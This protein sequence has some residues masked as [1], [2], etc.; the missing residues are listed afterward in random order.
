I[1]PP[2]SAKA[3][4]IVST[5]VAA[6][7][8]RNHIG[9]M[10]PDA[11]AP[12]ETAADDPATRPSIALLAGRHRR[13][14]AG[15][16]WI[17]SNEVAM[18]AA[19]KALAPGSLVTLRRADGSPLGV[20]MFNPHT[21]LAARLLDRD[22]ARPI[23]RRFLARPIGRARKL[24]ERL[25]DEPYYRLVHAEADGLPGLVVD[26]FG[27]ILVVQSNAAGMSRLEPLVLDAL[28]EL[29]DPEAIVLRNDSPARALEGLT[30]ETGVA[31]G[32]IEGPVRIHENG[33]IFRADLLAGQKTGGLFA[34]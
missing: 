14:E 33:N 5:A 31:R 34:Q 16:P 27:A 8:C 26:R 10:S 22:M 3:S 25:F 21:L 9:R 18:D 11:I 13:A 23:G 4:R 32:R 30:S 1:T 2:Q 15:H 6:G 7:C 24:R 17:Y 12:H 20:A 28:S 19:A 29:L